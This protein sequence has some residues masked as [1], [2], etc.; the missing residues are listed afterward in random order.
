[1]STESQDTLQD[2][3]SRFYQKA[4]GG[5]VEFIGSAKITWFEGR[6]LAWVSVGNLGFRCVGECSNLQTLRTYLEITERRSVFSKRG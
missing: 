2:L 4:K 3:I 6:Y 1:M 5:A